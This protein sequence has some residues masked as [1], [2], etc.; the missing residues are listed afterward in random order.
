MTLYADD[1]WVSL[2]SCD[3][4]SKFHSKISSLLLCTAHI[5]RRKRT[6]QDDYLP[7]QK[8]LSSHLFTRVFHPCSNVRGQVRFTETPCILHTGTWIQ[9]ILFFFKWRLYSFLKSCFFWAKQVEKLT[10][11]F[12]AL[13]SIREPPG[14][15]LTSACW[16][17][18]QS[19]KKST[20]LCRAYRSHRLREACSLMCFSWS[21]PW[22]WQ[23]K[24]S[25]GGVGDSQ[26]QF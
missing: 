23:D 14:R 18:S 1:S 2:D 19:K 4:S 22:L 9:T 12:W 7:L 15:D 6:L 5:K 20:Y 13:V 8:V 26:S 11:G 17:G 25:L 21:V 24:Y 3:K 16:K 10:G